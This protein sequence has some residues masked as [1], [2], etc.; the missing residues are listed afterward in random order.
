MYRIFPCT[1]YDSNI[2]TK[3]IAT[4]FNGTLEP[5]MQI[6][7]L[8]LLLCCVSM[9]DDAQFCVQIFAHLPPNAF[10]DTFLSA[11]RKSGKRVRVQKQL[12]KNSK[13]KPERDRESEL[14]RA[15]QSEKELKA[16]R[17]K[18]REGKSENEQARERLNEN[19]GARKRKP[20]KL[21]KER[22]KSERA[23]HWN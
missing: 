5:N 9:C 23:V 11:G 19:E 20:A 14:E 3:R 16:R 13:Q 15:G 17:E 7:V 1:F 2:N 12:G 8:L 10:I 6:V 21:W 4:R 22:E 18:E